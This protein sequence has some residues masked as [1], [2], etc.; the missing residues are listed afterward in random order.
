MNGDG[1]KA[2]PW[3][4]TSTHTERQDC[5]EL[6]QLGPGQISVRD[7]KDPNSPQLTFTR[8]ELAG[9]LNEIKLGKLEPRNGVPRQRRSLVCRGKLGILRSRGDQP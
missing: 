5:V 9:F 1:C 7:S 3:W 4:R 8:R 2:A 6:A